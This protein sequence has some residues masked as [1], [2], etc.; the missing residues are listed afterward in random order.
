MD[1]QLPPPPEW[2]TDSLTKFIEAAY[3]NRYA[4]FANKKEW[5][6]RLSALD[7]CFVRI[8]DGWINPQNPLTPMLFM[9]CHSAYRAACEHAMAGQVPE[10][11]PQIR[12]CLEYAAY[13]LHIHKNPDVGLTWLERNGDKPSKSAA[14]NEFTPARIRATIE[15]ANQHAANVFNELYERSIDFGAHPNVAGVLVSLEMTKFEGRK[16]YKSSYLQ[17]DGDA[18]DHTL[19]TTV[20][21]GI[22]ALEVLIEAFSERFELLG[23]NARLLEL[24]K[25]V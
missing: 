11:F 8:A 23:V 21:A 7:A 16:E 18:L 13:A 6:E 19:K 24:R 20:Q 12:A 25:G 3:R 1:E 22:C 9:R 4:T 14:R 10:A 5:F 15:K 2:G 17:G